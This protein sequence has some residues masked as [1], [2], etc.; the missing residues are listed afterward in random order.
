[1]LTIVN[2]TQ[3]RLKPHWLS[4]SASLVPS[5]PKRISP[6]FP[7]AGDKLHLK[8]VEKPMRFNTYKKFAS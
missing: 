3:N 1:M 2:N 4:S 5:K 8:L 6:C 7:I